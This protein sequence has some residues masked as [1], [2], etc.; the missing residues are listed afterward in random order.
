MAQ[1]GL[2]PAHRIGEHD[3]VGNSHRQEIQAPTPIIEAGDGTD[4]DRSFRLGLDQKEG[5][6]EV[7]KAPVEPHN[8]LIFR[9]AIDRPIAQSFTNGLVRLI[10]AR[11][12]GWFNP[13]G[14]KRP[15]EHICTGSRVQGC[16][17]REVD[18]KRI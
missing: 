4:D 7:D 9:V 13:T 10:G 3:S 18:T 16:C 5:E 15:D 17:C 14:S 8:Q 11:W 2:Y 12:R 1:V 6:T